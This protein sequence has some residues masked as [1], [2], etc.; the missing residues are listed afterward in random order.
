MEEQLSDPKQ[1]A[2]APCAMLENITI[3]L[4]LLPRSGVCPDE[5]LPYVLTCSIP[6]CWDV[7]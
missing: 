6:C 3:F 5:V 2:F 4:L 7:P 1:E